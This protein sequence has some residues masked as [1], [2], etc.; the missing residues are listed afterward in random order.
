MIAAMAGGPAAAMSAPRGAATTTS[1]GAASGDAK[2]ASAS[3]AES[4]SARRGA[5]PGGGESRTR[6]AGD[7]AAGGLDPAATAQAAAGRDAGQDAAERGDAASG[8][9]AALLAASGPTDAPSVAAIAPTAAPSVIADTTVP[10]ATLPEQFLALLSGSW[11]PAAA[12]ATAPVAGHPARPP[13]LP[14]SALPGE[15]VVVAPVPAGAAVDAANARAPLA[16]LAGLAS[17]ALPSIDR[18]GSDADTSP[19]LDAVALTTPAPATATARAAAPPPI[20]PLALPS[21]PDAGFDDGFG[22][23]ITWM[24][25]QR[26][27]HA[28]IRLN[29]EHVGPIEVRVQLE[30]NRVN[31]EFSSAHAEVRQAIEASLPRLREML[32]QHGLQLGQADVGQGQ[33][34]RRDAP[35]MGNGHDSDREAERDPRVTTQP[36]RAAR[37]LL[38]EYA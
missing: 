2:T 18:P 5:T 21:D 14:A 23:R 33:S 27:G 7:T 32:G 15:P 28:Q 12:D 37:G 1:N 38:D 29:P 17:A 11:V 30:G 13:A 4:A 34:G 20:A 24:A 26:L 6:L 3:P 16:V 22:T 25:E 36:V 19:A 9:F 10:G 35:T 8:E 31:A